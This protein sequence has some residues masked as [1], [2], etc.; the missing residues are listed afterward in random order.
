MNKDEI[1]RAVVF[2]RRRTL[3][4]LRPM[5]ADSFDAATA[6]P[7]WRVREVVA[8]LIT[9]D[10]AAITGR[11]LPVV[12][13]SSTD[14]LEAWNDH[15][16]GKWAG[17]PIP[18]LLVGLER[19]GRRFARFAR[20]LPEPLFRLRLPSAWGKQPGGMMIWIRAYD[21]W[22]HRQDIRRAL[23]MADDE[24][25]LAPVAEFLLR[26]IGY[27]TLPKLASERGE[28]TVSLTGAPLSEWRF[29]LGRGRSGPVPD[30][31]LGG[32]MAGEELG[33]PVAAPKNEAAAHVAAPAHAF[34]MAAAGRHSFEELRA[35]GLI[36]IDGDQDRAWALLRQIRIV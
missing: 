34:I 30:G 15:Q 16:V 21:E 36:T 18:E 4:L 11:L 1:L 31:G 8:H 24:V 35:N 29:D 28:V 2:E 19:W 5:R 10:I 14:R 27:S 26:A 12:F 13:S 25:D 3:R 9:T 23:G 17:R 22:V 33:G 20:L 7:G 32:S 6:L